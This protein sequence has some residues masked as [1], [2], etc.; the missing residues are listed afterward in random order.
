VTARGASDIVG[1]NMAA[2]GLAHRG[3]GR[4]PGSRWCARRSLRYSYL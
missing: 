1:A 4:S 3:Q 2:L